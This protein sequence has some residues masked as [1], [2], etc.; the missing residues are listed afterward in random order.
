MEPATAVRQWRA[1]CV[2]DCCSACASRAPMCSRE[3]TS[4]AKAA[5]LGPSRSCLARLRAGQ[6]HGK[7]HRWVQYSYRASFLLSWRFLSKTADGT[8]T[9]NPVIASPCGLGY[10]QHPIDVS[11][12][13]TT[14]ASEVCQKVKS[15][16]SWPSFLCTGF[17]PSGHTI[18]GVSAPFKTLLVVFC[19][20]LCGNPACFVR[21]DYAPLK[22]PRSGLPTVG[23]AR[24]VARQQAVSLPLIGAV[25]GARRLEVMRGLST[26]KHARFT[27]NQPLRIAT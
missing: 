20:Q 8:G 10:A 26:Y 25:W 19:G 14:P 1:D 23:V 16:R 17:S 21:L 15:C 7:S 5:G 27:G 6:L 2:T 24:S 13:Q 9:R 12:G 11:R 22:Y 3:T 4:V 18:S